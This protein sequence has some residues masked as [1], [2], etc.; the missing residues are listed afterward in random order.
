MAYRTG[1][2]VNTTL[3]ATVHWSTAAILTFADVV[4]IFHVYVDGLMPMPNRC[5]CTFNS[6]LL[7]GV[8]VFRIYYFS[9][10]VV[11]EKG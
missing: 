8:N 6:S 5:P 2:P 4:D 11:F 9:V 10:K 3:V 1:T 7:I